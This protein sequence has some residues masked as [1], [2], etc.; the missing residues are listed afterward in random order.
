MFSNKLVCRYH[1][2]KKIIPNERI[3]IQR[4]G[5]GSHALL[6]RDTSLNDAGTYLAIARNSHGTAQSSAI[7]D[8][9]STSFFCFVFIIL[10]FLAP[11][12]DNIKFDGSFDVT[13]Y[14]T[15]E[16]GFKKQNFKSLPTP[17]DRGP[18][19]KSFFFLLN[20]CHIIIFRCYKSSF[21][22]FMDTN[23]TFAAPLST[24]NICA[25]N[26][27]IA[28]QRMVIGECFFFIT[29]FFF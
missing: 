24:D 9:S 7:L 3:Q 26:S 29:F 21:N 23:K 15:E 13:P 2:G 10:L 12:L 8:V 27:R 1:N 11:L 16:Y 6:I 25:R 17:P 20:F 5:G 22:S 14:L 4:C 18:F 19:I 28:I